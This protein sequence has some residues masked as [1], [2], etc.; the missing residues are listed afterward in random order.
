MLSPASSS[1]VEPA[2]SGGEE[3]GSSRRKRGGGIQG[4]LREDEIERG[5]ERKRGRYLT[6]GRGVGG[7]GVRV[8]R[9]AHKQTIKR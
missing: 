5:K 2:I 9:E 1:P 8:T 3:V 4:E 7:R 6:G